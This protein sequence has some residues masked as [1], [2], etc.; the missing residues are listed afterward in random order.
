MLHCLRKVLEGSDPGPRCQTAAIALGACCMQLGAAAIDEATNC[1][2]AAVGPMSAVEACVAN[3]P[4]AG[5]PVVVLLLNR[6][7][8]SMSL[9]AS[10]SG[11]GGWARQS[12]ATRASDSG[13][14]GYA[15]DG[16]PCGS[17]NRRLTAE[18]VTADVRCP[19]LCAPVSAR[20]L[21]LS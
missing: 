16:A 11:G 6:L 17:G 8:W 9:V 15:E 12:A 18:V 7:A 10:D 13:S 20:F 1:G 14:D 3:R 19:A 2:T 21:S 5:L 4:H